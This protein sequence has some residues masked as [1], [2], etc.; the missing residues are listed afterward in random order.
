MQEVPRRGGRALGQLASYSVR[1][2]RTKTHCG[3]FPAAHVRARR[4]AEL[5]SIAGSG[6]G[7]HGGAGGTAVR[8]TPV[9][10]LIASTSSAFCTPSIRAAAMIVAD[11]AAFD[12]TQP[13]GSG[14]RGGSQAGIPPGLAQE[15][16]ARPE[17]QIPDR[18]GRAIR[19]CATGGHLHL[20]VWAVPCAS[21]SFPVAVAVALVPT[22]ALPRLDP[23]VRSAPSKLGARCTILV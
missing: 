13:A 7:I 5:S 20:C 3:T 22:S 6:V 9:S 15:N 11:V 2:R 4:Q 21:V 1:A 16:T 17:E 8:T 18:M 12:T 23:P 14:N 19:S 10:R